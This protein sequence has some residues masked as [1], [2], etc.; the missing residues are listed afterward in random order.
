MGYETKAVLAHFGAMKADTLTEEHCDA[1]I[2][3]RRKLGR[4]D[5]TIWT[6]LGHLRSSLRWAERKNLIGKAPAIKRPPRPAPRDKRLTK[7]QARA[8]IDACEKPHVKLFVRLALATAARMGALLD[9]TWDRVDFDQGVIRLHNPAKERTHKGRAL[10]PM[11]GQIMEALREAQAGSTGAWVIEWGGRRVL[12]VK[13][14]IAEAGKRSGLTWVTAHVFRHSA[15]C[16]MAEGGVPMS[17]IAQYLGHSSTRV[18]ETVY[19]RYSP[20]YLRG[21]AKALEL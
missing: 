4:S 18:T 17:E 20:T 7:D 14:G 19:A 5:G 3:A 15:A 2:A 1:Y 11:N 12:N 16:F 13:K 10:V 9:L 21:A 8:F 6:E